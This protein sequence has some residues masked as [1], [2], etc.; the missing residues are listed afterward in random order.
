MKDPQNKTVILSL[1]IRCKWMDSTQILSFITLS[2]SGQ[3]LLP[4]AFTAPTCTTA[5][6]FLEVGK[7]DYQIQ[8]RLKCFGEDGCSFNVCR[9]PG[10]ATGWWKSRAIQI[11]SRWFALS[12]LEHSCSWGC[13]GKHHRISSQQWVIQSFWFKNH[14][15]TTVSE[16]VKFLVS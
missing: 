8:M 6:W 2:P 5:P 13:W 10:T 15:V 1:C 9:V 14:M 16:F 11:L 7:R 4:D 3:Q 12:S